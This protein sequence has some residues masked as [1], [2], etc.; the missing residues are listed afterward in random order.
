MSG[1]EARRQQ[2]HEHILRCVA[3]TPDGK[4]AFSASWD[5]TIRMWDI[6]KG[7]AIGKFEG[8]TAGVYKVL[9][10]KDG[11]KMVTSSEDRTVRI[12]DTESVSLLKTLEGK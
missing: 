1:S 5:K 8:H 2:G 9:V 10:T 6:E 3:T 11:R 12:W 7:T 4:K